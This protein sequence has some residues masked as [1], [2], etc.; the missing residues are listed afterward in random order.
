[1]ERLNGTIF[2][3]AHK[4]LLQV[5]PTASNLARRRK[6]DDPNCPLCKKCCPQTNKHV[7]ANCSAPA[8]LQSY[9]TRHNEILQII[10]MWLQTVIP[11]P[12]E[13]FAD[14]GEGQ[15]KPTHGLFT[16]ARPDIA[17]T[18][19]TEI[20]II[21]LTVCHESNLDNS[22]QY[23]INKY[24]NL[25]ECRTDRT[26]DKDIVCYT[27]EVSTLGLLSPDD[28]LTRGLGIPRIPKEIKETIMKSVL[29]CLFKI[30][31]NRNSI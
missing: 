6:T 2:N 21:E 20:N 15:Y 29:N 31:C 3:F 22:K 9:T 11:S 18:S 16:S 12:Q 25:M 5:L 7:L 8:A 10:V 4:A 30:D 17:I 14:L 28:D 26:I 27:I 23:K 1:V 13:I 24:Q 19:N